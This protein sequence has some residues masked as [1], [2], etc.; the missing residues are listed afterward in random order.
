MTSAPDSAA[1]DSVLVTGSDIY[2]PKGCRRITGAPLPPHGTPTPTTSLEKLNER[3]ERLAFG[4]GPDDGSRPPMETYTIKAAEYG[5]VVSATPEYIRWFLR[6]YPAA[7]REDRVSLQASG[8][9]PEGVGGTQNRTS[10]LTRF[11]SP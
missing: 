7:G 5:D 1:S 8:P 10:P 3:L 6:T 11:K 4:P 9:A 2:A